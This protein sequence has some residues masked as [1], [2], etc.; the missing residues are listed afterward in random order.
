MNAAYRR[1]LIHIVACC[2]AIGLVAPRCAE[3]QQDVAAFLA[4][5]AIAF[6]MHEAGHVAFDVAFDASPGVKKVSF[7]SVPFFAIT[8]PEVSPVREFSISSAGFW[9]QEGTNEILLTRNAPLR[10]RHAPLL[11]GMFA[12]NVL[13]SVAYAS[14]S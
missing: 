7:G 6:A 14:S 13:A 10:H 11:K 12:F 9:V 2:C 4:G 1:T 3:A 5:G 8:H